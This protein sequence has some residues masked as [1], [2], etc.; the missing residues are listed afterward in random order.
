MLLGGD[1]GCLMNIAG[2]LQREG[3][4]IAVRH[5]AEVLAGQLDQPPIGAPGDTQAQSVRSEASR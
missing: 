3:K 2:K 5:V 4:T 1:L